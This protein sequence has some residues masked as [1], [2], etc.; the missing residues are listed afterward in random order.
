M[1]GLAFNPFKRYP[2]LRYKN[3]Y[4]LNKYTTLYRGV[5][6]LNYLIKN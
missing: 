1:P 4:G 6:C 2:S 3:E 5:K